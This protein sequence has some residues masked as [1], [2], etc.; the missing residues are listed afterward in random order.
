[1]P[2]PA[3]GALPPADAAAAVPGQ[4]P[5]LPPAPKDYSFGSSSLSILF[6][7]N[8]VEQMKSAIRT[9]E[10]IDP[11]AQPQQ[12]VDIP[13]APSVQAP[14]EPDRYPVFFLSSIVYETPSE[15]SLWL[16]GHKITS[17]QNETDVT[18]VSLTKD[19]ATFLW[20]PSFVEALMRRYSTQAFAPVDGVKNKLTVA[21]SVNFDPKTS[22]FTFTLKSNQSFSPGYFSTFEGYIDSPALP[23]LDTN[24]QDG[25]TDLMNGVFPPSNP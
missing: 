2:S 18:V 15:W 1:M 9:F 19:S 6:L 22:V 7:P 11:G 23:A 3:L 25:F 17:R 21:Q 14:A 5:A 13:V 20:K 12:Q 16:S 4:A 8:Q 24:G 10:D